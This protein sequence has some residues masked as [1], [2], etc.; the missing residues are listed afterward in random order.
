MRGFLIENQFHI[1]AFNIFFESNVKR[2]YC[3][4]YFEFTRILAPCRAYLN[5]RFL[6]G[7]SCSFHSIL[8]YLEI[9]MGNYERNS[10]KHNNNNKNNNNDNNNSNNNKKN[11][12]NNSNYNKVATIVIIL[13]GFPDITSSQMSFWAHY[14]ISR[15]EK[16]Q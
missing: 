6:V 3:Y 5:H 13:R 15:Y 14:T 4:D 16:I 11:N 12:D 1:W 9:L 10:L 8:A 7:L 2:K